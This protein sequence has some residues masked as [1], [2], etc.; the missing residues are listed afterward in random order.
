MTN[1]PFVNFAFAATGAPTPRTTPDRLAEVKN[2]KDLSGADVT[3]IYTA[4][5]A[6]NP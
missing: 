6:G 3:A 1:L 2:V 5:L 4:G